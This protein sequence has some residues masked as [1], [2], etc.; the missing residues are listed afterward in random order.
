M[1]NKFTLIE[2][3]VVIAIIAILASMLLPALNSARAR[4]KSVKCASNLKS[5]G[6]A[7]FMYSTDYDG[8]GVLVMRTSPWGNGWN[9]NA[10]YAKAF[11]TNCNFDATGAS[12]GN[13]SV[14]SLCPESYAVLTN[15]GKYASVVYS[16]SRNGEYGSS[17]DSPSDRC[18]KVAKIRNP[19]SKLLAVDG[20]DV[21]VYQYQANYNIYYRVY[22]EKYVNSMVAYRHNTGLNAAFYDGHVGTAIHWQTI[23]D[24]SLSQWQ[25]DPRSNAI[26]NKY[27]NLWPNQQ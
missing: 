23:C 13:W 15:T 24:P 27:W 18:T 12:T 26:Y 22:G 11:G 14:S 2:L 7:E 5:F 3:L 1:K 16:Y 20:V 19:S 4:A 8:W 6:P 9:F 10:A 21:M 17:W 25:A